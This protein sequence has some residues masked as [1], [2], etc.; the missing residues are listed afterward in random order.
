[1]FAYCGNN[2][3]ARVEI[4]GYFWDIVLDVISLC[5][6][7]VDVIKHPEDPTAWMSLGADTASLVIPFAT[8][9]GVAVKALTKADKTVDTIKAINK[10]DKTKDTVKIG[11]NVGDNITNLTKAG[12]IPSWTTVRQRYWK[13]EALFNPIAYSESNL[14]LMKKGRAPLVELNGNLYPMELHHITP[15]SL[16]G[17]NEYDNLLRLAPWEHAEYDR[18]RYFIAK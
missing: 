15:R 5:A 8:G 18:F 3:V 11:W 9:G 13:N 2:P 1:M 16:G 17:S 7:V 6:S 14:S 10:V 4:G 12:N